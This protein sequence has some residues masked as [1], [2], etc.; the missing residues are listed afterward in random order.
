MKWS[1]IRSVI[2]SLLLVFPCAAARLDIDAATAKSMGLEDRPE[3]NPNQHSR[4]PVRAYRLK[5]KPFNLA[6]SER[7]MFKFGLPKG[8]SSKTMQGIR[9]FQFEHSI[10]SY[11]E[12]KSEYFFSTDTVPDLEAEDI[13]PDNEIKEKS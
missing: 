4:H 9:T 3:T 2:P 11:S 5:N 6:E 12:E 8:L 13:I 1:K 10:F 7:L